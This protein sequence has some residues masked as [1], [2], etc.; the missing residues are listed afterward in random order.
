[1]CKLVCFIIPL[2]AGAAE[3]PVRE[4]VLY[5]NG[6]GYFVRSGEVPRGE[7]VRLEFRETE[8]ND[9]LKSLTVSGQA[10]SELRYDS[11]E[12]ID[13]KLADFPFTLSDKLTLAAFLDRLKGARVE[14]KFGPETL[15]GVIVSGRNAPAEKDRG[16]RDMLVLMLDSGEL[17]TVDLAAAQSIRFADPVV[18]DQLAAYLR[19]LSQ[20]RSKE[21]RAVYVGEP[22]SSSRQITASYMVPTPVWKSSYRLM[23][24][25]KPQPLLE[26]WAIVD[27]TS[28]DD[29]SNIRLAVVSGRPVSFVSQ[30]YDPKYVERQSVELAEFGPLAPTV[31]EGVV[32]GLA[33]APPPPAP[34]AAP[35]CRAFKR[36]EIPA[37]SQ[38]V[39]VEGD[40]AA[41]APAAEGAEIGEL[42]EYGFTSPVTIK[43][44]ESA[45]LPF[46]REGVTAR[47]LLIYSGDGINPLNA[48]EVTN[49]TGKTLDGGPIT[50]FESKSYAGEA[51]METCKSGDK[52]LISYA[53][54]LGTRITTAYETSADV[55]RSIHMARGILMTRSAL[56]ETR[57]YTIK[58]VDQKPKTLVLEHGVRPGF[59]LVNQKP[60][61]KTAHAYRFEV[62]LA[63]GASEKFPVTEERIYDNTMLIA[64]LTPDVLLTYVQNKALSETGRQRLEQIASKKQSIA[65][66]DQELKRV[67]D[68]SAELIADQGRLRQNIDSLN[69][70]SGQQERV[71]QYARDLSTT[72]AKLAAARDQRRDLEQKKTQLNR[73]LNSL[74]ET[75]EF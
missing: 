43:R 5:K 34:A 71:Q 42:F 49:S 35:E 69:R 1:M 10:V 73:E 6:V 8:M 33:A 47:K 38:T 24:G 63:P 65:G 41:P 9:V 4:V 64:S 17:R 67:Q 46:L 13:R 23:F 31:H 3:L 54:D 57:T 55:I 12:P 50:V 14:I 30:L 19:V 48:V 70:V 44:G 37:S 72:E 59:E 28:G 36:L 26:G 75:A 22:A 68:E 20:A 21:K 52:R 53:V 18:Q 61:E 32:A 51:L 58:N 40:A 16:E 66:N 74:I 11:N 7:P 60:S 56:R 2:L 39:S 29:W 15:R 62:K 45:L 25:D 27:N